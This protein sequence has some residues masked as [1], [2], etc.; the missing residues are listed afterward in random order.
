MLCKLNDSKRTS[1]MTDLYLAGIEYNG[2]WEDLGM[3]TFT[4]MKTGSTFVIEELN[5]DMAINEVIN[6]RQRFIDAESE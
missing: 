3:Y 1:L 6:V 4:D 2:Y 5:Y